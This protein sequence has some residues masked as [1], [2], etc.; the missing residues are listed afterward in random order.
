MTPTSQA[1]ANILVNV[2][3]N[4]TRYVDHDTNFCKVCG[5]PIP[6]LQIG[7]GKWLN[8]PTCKP[9][10]DAAIEDEWHTF[11]QQTARD[12]MASR[13]RKITKQSVM[14]QALTTANF[15]NFIPRA[16][17][18]RV[19]NAARDFVQGFDSAGRG[20][21]FSGVPGNGKS[22]LAAAIHNR[23]VQ[24]GHVCLFLDYPQL[25][26]LA[27]STFSKQS[28]ISVSDIVASAIQAEL[29][30]LDE[31][32]LGKVTEWEYKELLFPII[33]GRI[34]KPTNYTSNTSLER[35]ER[36]LAQDKN[37]TQLDEHGRLYDRLVSGVRAYVNMAT[38][39]RREDAGLY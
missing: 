14:N 17:T 38:S 16:G 27:K 37:G 12:N 7:P 2:S 36:W 21:Y 11:E 29:L 26:Q 39:K 1:I 30:T 35:V 15:D 3:V 24:Q 10:V 28:D 6:L 31:F 33:N 34:G 19:L 25:V 23:L 18:E 5:A 9:C 32:G 13:M 8:Q 4:I 20:L 22:H